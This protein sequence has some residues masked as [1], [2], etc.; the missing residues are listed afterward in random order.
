V[1]K[2][3]LVL[4]ALALLSVSP[5][6]AQYSAVIAACRWDSK[7]LC[8]DVVPQGGGL[9]RCIEEKFDALGYSC[10]AALVRITAVR[11]A[12]GADIAQQCPGTKPGAGR[13]LLCVKA[14]YAALSAP[15]REAIGHAA[16]RNV[17]GR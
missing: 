3:C 7:Q 11:Q 17:P 12:C 14:H 15:C 9:A 8:A 13:V 2:S 10:K 1:G 4:A 16:E 6:F 5:A